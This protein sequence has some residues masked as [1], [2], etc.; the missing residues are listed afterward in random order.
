MQR[1]NTNRKR[2]EDMKRALQEW[3]QT[4]PEIFRKLVKKEQ[5]I[6]NITF[7]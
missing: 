6:L 5:V 4:D 2:E 1:E 7:Q 3:R